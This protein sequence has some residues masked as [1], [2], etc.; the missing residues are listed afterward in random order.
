MKKKISVLG[1]SISTLQGYNPPDYKCFYRQAMCG[2]RD[3]HDTWWGRVIDYYDGSFL[4]N[5]SWAGSRVTCL[6]DAGSMFPSACSKERTQNLHFQTEFPDAIFIYMGTNDWLEGVPLKTGE[7]R[8]FSGFPELVF[9]TAY[10]LMLKRVK[11]NYPMARIICIPIIPS[12]I[13]EDVNYTFP[14]SVYGCGYMEFNEVIRKEAQ[15]I[16]ATYADA[17]GQG[18]LYESFDGVHPDMKGMK[19]IAELIIGGIGGSSF[20]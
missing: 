5:D 6:V 3:M 12:F 19:T 14:L 16:G 9:E 8:H 1:D 11:R 17:T 20:I 7:V 15:M 2:I 13:P 10:R 18:K 4:M